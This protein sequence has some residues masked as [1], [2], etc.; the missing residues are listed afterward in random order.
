MEVFFRETLNLYPYTSILFYV[1]NTILKRNVEF[2]VR[3]LSICFRRKY[4][5]RTTG[6]GSSQGTIRGTQ[7]PSCRILCSYRSRLF[8]SERAR[9]LAFRSILLRPERFPPFFSLLALC[10]TFRF[11]LAFSDVP[12]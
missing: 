8:A 1:G 3:F 2:L 10:S 9:P 4:Q 6:S 5:N 11:I 7:D 12:S